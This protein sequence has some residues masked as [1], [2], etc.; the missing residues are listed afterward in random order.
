MYPI[1]TISSYVSYSHNFKLCILFPQFQAMYL[2]PTISSY[3]SY[4]H[5]FKLCILFPQFQA[6]N[7]FHT[8]SSYVSYSHNFNVFWGNYYMWPIIERVAYWIHIRIYWI[9]IKIHPFFI[10][11]WIPI[12]S[13][14]ASYS[15]NFKLCILFPQFQA[16]YPFHTISN[17]VSYSHNFK[18]CIIFSQFQ[19][20][21]PIHTISSYVFYSHNFNVFWRNFMWPIIERVAYWIHIRTYWIVIKIPPFFIFMWIQFFVLVVPA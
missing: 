8:I 2:I 1:P 9:V 6:M 12:I 4:F 7:P 14:Y 13:S 17:Y 19:A 21:Y 11:M 16:I 18:L 3:A 5:N 10:F 20:M 15:H